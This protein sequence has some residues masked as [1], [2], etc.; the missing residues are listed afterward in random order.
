MG[1]CFDF[2]VFGV[3]YTTSDGAFFDQSPISKLYLS[4]YNFLLF[5]FYLIL[6]HHKRPLLIGLPHDAERPRVRHYSVQ[7]LR[8]VL[9][10]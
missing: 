8:V 9:C 2:L 3:E 5:F 10:I 1:I 4:N 7:R 6:L